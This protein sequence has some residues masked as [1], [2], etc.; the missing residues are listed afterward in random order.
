VASFRV[1]IKNPRFER[2]LHRAE[3]DPRKADEAV[4]A[5]EFA[6]ARHPERGFPV[7]SLFI[8]P[9]YVRA[10]EHVVYYTFDDVQVELVSLRASSEDSW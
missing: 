6:L 9:I 10:V 8:W 2:E 5:M 4:E 1:V 7:A 3:P